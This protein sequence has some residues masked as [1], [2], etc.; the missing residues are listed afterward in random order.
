MFKKI[1]KF[2]NLNNFI[3]NNC[4]LKNINFK[5]SFVSESLKISPAAR[6]LLSANLIDPSL[7][8]PTGPKSIITKFDVIQFLHKL[9]IST[10]NSTSNSKLIS[11]NSNSNLTSQPLKT[12]I[13]ESQPTPT[14]QITAPPQSIKV[15]TFGQFNEEILNQES[16]QIGEQIQLQKFNIPHIYLSNEI[17]VTSLAN[18]V[19]SHSELTNFIVKAIGVSAA[20]MREVNVTFQEDFI[21]QY[22]DV[23]ILVYEQLSQKQYIIPKAN[24]NPIDTF[25]Q[26][27][28][29]NTSNFFPTMRLNIIDKKTIENEFG[30]ESSTQILDFNIACAITISKIE[31]KLV[32]IDDKVTVCQ[33]MNINL[34]CDERAIPIEIAAHYLQIL[35]RKLNNP[36]ELLL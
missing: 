21:R 36:I 5:K 26:F 31:K 17:E 8:V 16:K 35:S 32:I 24:K 33:V 27:K 1:N 15:T 18:L 12:S 34:T 7:I 20:L 22:R 4:H 13:N 29:D 9:A 3:N 25:D 28:I 23:N 30:I 2:K 10:T 6:Y 14:I 11:S 19:S